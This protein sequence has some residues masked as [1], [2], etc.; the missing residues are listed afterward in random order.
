MGRVNQ[1]ETSNME[2]LQ[3]VSRLQERTGPKAMTNPS[4][5]RVLDSPRPAPPPGVLPPQS[6][7]DIQGSC[8]PPCSRKMLTAGQILQG[9]LLFSLDRT[10]HQS[11]A[12]Q[13]IPPRH[14]SSDVSLSFAAHTGS[15][16]SPEYSHLQVPH[17]T[18]QN[19]SALPFVSPSCP[20]G[21]VSTL[22]PQHAFSLLP[23]LFQSY[24]AH[25]HQVLSTSPFCISSS[26]Y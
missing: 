22:L 15:P 18:P 23:N 20:P 13:Q 4:D 9:S 19:C 3:K 26:P 25:L 16:A 2:M 10:L 8:C 21:S 17:A 5:I 12:H 1:E 24:L 11:L 7:L 6:G 14:V